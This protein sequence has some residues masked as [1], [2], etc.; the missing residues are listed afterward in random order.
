[1]NQPTCSILLVDDD[2]A[3]CTS[4][5]DVL[6]VM[7]H[8]VE[9]A[10]SGHEA[11]AA[12]EQR[13]FD[14]VVLDIGLP[15]LSG[16]ELVSRLE[17]SHPEIEI[18]IVTG[19]ASYDYAM[20]AVSRST[21]GFLVKPIDLDRLLAIVDRVAQRAAAEMERERL[22]H[23]LEDQN[24]E[25][26]RY[27][28]TVSHDLK[29]PLLTIKGFLGM[30]EMNVKAGKTEKSADDIRRVSEA[31]DCMGQ[32]LDDVL[33]LSQLGRVVNSPEE[34]ALSSLAEEAVDG[35]ASLLGRHRLEIIKI[36]PE[37]PVV[38]G[39]RSRLLELFVA[40]V[41]NAVKFLGR[42]PQPRIEIG[43]EHRTDGPVCYV[44]DNGIGIDRLYH[45]KIFGLFEQLDPRY[46]GTGIG[47]PLAR[48]I[49]EVHGGRIW[50]ESEG[51][52]AGSSFCFTLR[53]SP[54]SIKGPDCSGS[55]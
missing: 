39:D 20:R 21:I 22:I 55:P 50:V 38:H 7:H 54:V 41:E 31:A 33:K 34:I 43:V 47:L 48:R 37:M 5:G 2:P 45:E 17:Q 35:V 6:A 36:A 11:L 10:H 32:L 29:A 13:D 14:L 16:L 18:L 8:Q 3:V 1:M 12:C 44:R 19:Q 40:L 51:L 46:Q 53:Q 4:L 27:A 52:G 49:V 30:I 24:A 28:Y 9:S 42:N 23:Q 15:D 26:E 25:L